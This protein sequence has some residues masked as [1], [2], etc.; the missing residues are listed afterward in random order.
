MMLPFF[1]LE[2]LLDWKQNADEIIVKLNLGSGSLKVEDVDTFFTDT[3]C[4]IKLPGTRNGVT[5]ANV[6]PAVLGTSL[7]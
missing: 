3:D 7:D 1:F 2:L 5:A 6:S 4:V